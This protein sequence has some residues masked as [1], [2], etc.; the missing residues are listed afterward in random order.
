M[1]GSTMKIKMIE[2]KI[3]SILHFLLWMF[4]LPALPFLTIDILLEQLENRMYD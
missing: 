1:I 2:H 3:Q 4:I